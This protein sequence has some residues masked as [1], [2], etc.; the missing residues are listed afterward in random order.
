MN[1]NIINEVCQSTAISNSAKAFYRSIVDHTLKEGYAW[2]TNGYWAKLFSVSTRTIQNWLKELKDAGF[3]ELEITR[4]HLRKVFLAGK[5]HLKRQLQGV[6]NSMQRGYEKVFAQKK[7]LKE[8]VLKKEIKIS[9]TS[10]SP[11]GVKP[12]ENPIA[13]GFINQARAKLGLQP[14]NWNIKTNESESIASI[15]QS[16]P[17]SR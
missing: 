15:F 11:D 4:N 3:I 17:F 14:R 8:K 10:N 7:E 16:L 2:A 12:S 6:R 13:L 1:Q 9:N 5:Q